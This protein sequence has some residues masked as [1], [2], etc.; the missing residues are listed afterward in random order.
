MAEEERQKNGSYNINIYTMTIEADT[1]LGAEVELPFWYKV[2]NGSLFQVQYNEYMLLK[3]I[4]NDEQGQF[5]EVGQADNISN[6]IK[7][8]ANAYAKAGS[9]LVFIVKGERSNE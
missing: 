2:G 7:L 6:K 4:D 1:E 8:A 3:A 9:I 5:Y